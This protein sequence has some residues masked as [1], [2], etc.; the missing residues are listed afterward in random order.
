MLHLPSPL[1]PAVAH[2]DSDFNSTMFSLLNQDRAQHGVAALQWSSTVGAIAESSSYSGCGYPVNGRAE[3]MI[4]RNYFSHTIESCGSQSVFDMLHAGGVS[5]SSAAENLGYASGFSDGASAARWMNDQF[6]QSSVHTENILDPKFT[7]VGVGSWWTASGQT[8]SGAGSQLNDVVVGAVEFIAAPSGS[9]SAPP[10]TAAPRVSQTPRPSSP[11]RTTSS[12][13]SGSGG[14]AAPA[15]RPAGV[16]PRPALPETGVLF[17]DPLE[18]DAAATPVAPERMR[19][20]SSPAAQA[21]R[22]SELPAV[23]MEVACGGVVLAGLA[24]VRRG[25][26]RRRGKRRPP[27]PRTVYPAG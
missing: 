13:G 22:T 4:Q 5:Y 3:D 8:W 19:V 6:M 18:D 24:L 16:A 10:P 9:T 14:R 20:V 27:S 23:S 1:A 12:G 25:I 17:I 26:A 7:A 21:A 11:V 2:A 15:A